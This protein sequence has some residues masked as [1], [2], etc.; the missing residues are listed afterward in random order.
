MNSRVRRV[1]PAVALLV[2]AALV[3][4][5][6]FAASPR[7]DAS[8]VASEIEDDIAAFLVNAD[9]AD[10]V[11]AVL[12]Y[13]NGEPVLEQYTGATADEYRNTWSVTKSVMSALIGIAIEDGF[14][15][16]V[17]ASLGDLLPSFATDMTPDVAAITLKQLLT[18]TGSFPAAT[19][20]EPFMASQDW[21]R[22]ILAERAAAGPASN[23]FL[24]SN[25]GPQVLSA[26][27][28]EA[29]GQS[30]LDYA[31]DN[32]FEP[33]AIQTDPAID[34][35]LGHAGNDDT[36]RLTQYT[37]ADFV[38]PVD[39]QGLAAGFAYLKLR[40]Q[41]LAAIGLAY[42]AGGESPQG[43]QI[44]PAA[45]VE[46]ST[47]THVELDGGDGYGYLWLVTEAD[48]AAAYFA[49]GLGGQLIEVVPERRLVVIVSTQYDE[50]D[51]ARDVKAVS[52]GSLLDLVSMWIAPHFP[53]D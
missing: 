18:Q 34:L 6:C 42:L 38:W 37:A 15:S 16:G 7:R 48:G 33:L 47:T 39:P 14:I 51:P 24:Y 28:V 53:A 25:A 46:T 27:L 44:V 50:L 43:E 20:D 29:T 23:E 5:G 45:W 12:I 49:S 22:A 3:L 9:D 21:I 41:D 19:L 1:V 2:G 26:V 8:E 35:V 52:A 31:R 40:P 32:L 30:V 11:R 17:G 10:Q 36:E 4:D 13:H